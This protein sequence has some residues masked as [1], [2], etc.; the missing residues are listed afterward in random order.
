MLHRLYSET[1]LLVQPI[2]FQSGINII[3][4][5]YSA[6][7]EAKNINGIGKS[8][9]IRLI[10]YCFLSGKAEDTFKK[11]QYDFLRKEEHNIILEFDVS[12]KKHFIK[13]Y[14]SDR[15]IIYIGFS[16]KNFDTYSK[17]DAKILL[18]DLLFPIED[19]KVFYQGNRLGTLLNFFIKDDINAQKRID[20]INFLDY[21]SNSKDIA[22]YNFY[23]LNLPTKGLDSYIEVSKEYEN[24][25]KAIKELNDT[26]IATTGKTVQV[27]KTERIQIQK[28]ID[29]LENSLKEYRFLGK[30]QSVE[31][32]LVIL[33]KKINE[34]LETYHLLN[35]EFK[36]LKELYD[37]DIEIDTVQIQKVYNESLSTFGDLVKK[38]L[39]DV[40]SFKKDILNNRNKFLVKKEKILE[41]N[42][43][44]VLSEISSLESERSK[45]YKTLKEKGA[46]ESIENTY[47]EIIQERSGLEKTSRYVGQI[48]DFERIIL[49]LN[50]VIDTRKREII[51][52]LEQFEGTLNTLR[53]FFKE[54][55][56]NAIFIEEDNDSAYFDIQLLPTS[57]KNSLPFKILVEIPKADS[58]G[59]S[60]L[61]IVAYD[62][63]LFLKNI[64]ES[65]KTPNFLIHDG[66]F[67]SI[68]HRTITNTLNYIS[69]KFN[70]LQNFQYI[71]TFNEDEIE[72]PEDKNQTYGTFDFD[73]KKKCVITLY[74]TPEKML[75]KRD[76][77]N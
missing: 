10:E 39:D 36:R 11:R 59:Q 66:V 43:A 2:P 27:F 38:T 44:I 49:D 23:L 17:S 46:L 55:L 15:D 29:L 16:P 70:E 64:S 45:L 8:S 62:L 57:A 56:E 37:Y 12:G 65:R 13:R 67:H 73:W 51:E 54:I 33:T 34:K 58:L 74:D 50:V 68:S 18:N 75:F 1:N 53:S 52:E 40:I 26:V 22:F 60:K 61:K 6:T 72:I 32:D 77:P 25:R 4:G 76:I 71:V 3:L 5:K 28:K 63:M 24:K 35:H 69:R 9:I 47:K 31:N 20:P 42:I 48:E 21:T 7:K 14:F 30:Y 41:E 19:T